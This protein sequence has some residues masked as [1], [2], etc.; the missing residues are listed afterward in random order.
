MHT[1]RDLIAKGT[2]NDDGHIII[3]CVCRCNVNK[4]RVDR[5]FDGKEKIHKGP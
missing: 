1:W 3:F 2:N 4:T 5:K